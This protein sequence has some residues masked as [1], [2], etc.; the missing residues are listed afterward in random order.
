MLLLLLYVVLLLLYVGYTGGGCGQSQDRPGY[1]YVV[2]SLP[3]N[4]R[5]PGTTGGWMGRDLAPLEP[6]PRY[7]ELGILTQRRQPPSVVVPYRPPARPVEPRGGND[8]SWGEHVRL[9]NKQWDSRMGAKIRA[10]SEY[11]Q[12]GGGDALDQLVGIQAERQQ[13]LRIKAPPVARRLHDNIPRRQHALPPVD[14]LDAF[15][16]FVRDREQFTETKPLAIPGAY[17]GKGVRAAAQPGLTTKLGLHI[18]SH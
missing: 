4:E 5:P 8:L 3:T 16:K 11:A 12:A 18:V 7:R 10:A 6:R 2:V 9:Q 15:A 1:M 14:E 17:V 13:R